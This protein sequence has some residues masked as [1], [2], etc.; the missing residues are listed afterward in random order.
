MEHTEPVAEERGLLTLEQ[1]DAG[2][3]LVNY[4]TRRPCK[5]S[6]CA[7]ITGFITMALVLGFVAQHA[8]PQSISLRVTKLVC[9][10]GW[11]QGCEDIEP[12][13][14]DMP[15]AQDY[16][17]ADALQE[18]GKER[19][20]IGEDF[21]EK[22]LSRLW[23]EMAWKD[24]AQQQLW[25]LT[26]L[27]EAGLS[28]TVNKQHWLFERAME[29]N[30][31]VASLMCDFG[32]AVNKT[33]SCEQ[34][35]NK[36][37]GDHYN[38]QQAYMWNRMGTIG[39]TYHTW[40]N[41]YDPKACF[42]E[43]LSR[44]WNMAA[45]WNGLGETL[46]GWKMGH[47][48]AAEIREVQAYVHALKISSNFS[49][50]WTNLGDNGGGTVNSVD[51]SAEHCYLKALMAKPE[52][53]LAWRGL[54]EAGGFT[55]KQK[56]YAAKNCIEH[57]LKL[58]PSDARIWMSL[59]KMGGGMFDGKFYSNKEC[60]QKALNLDNA[61]SAVRSKAWMLLGDLD[62]G[63]VNLT[64]MDARGCY[65]KA[66]EASQEEAESWAKL[67]NVGGG[68]VSGKKFSK[69]DCYQKAITQITSTFN[70]RYAAPDKESEFEANAS[71]WSGLG[72]LGG[73]HVGGKWVNAT[74]CYAAALWNK[75]DFSHAW[76]RLGDLGGA[77]VYFRLLSSRLPRGMTSGEFYD[78]QRCRDIAAHVNDKDP[79]LFVALGWQGGGN[80][81]G[82]HYDKTGSFIKALELKSTFAP[83]WN[84]LGQAGGGMVDSKIYSD[85]DCIKMAMQYQPD[86][87]DAWLQFC[88]RGGG[89]VNGINYQNAECYG[90]VLELPDSSAS[91]RRSAWLEL[92]KAGGGN[93]SGKWMDK[94]A[95]NRTADE[96]K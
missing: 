95:C 6:S 67:G 26:F 65:Q 7:A 61:A 88:F 10:G 89:D 25:S 44:N 35:K 24:E 94:K 27:K 57:A 79:E 30:S 14:Q 22:V 2:G 54:G 70:K 81:T 69:E 63:V 20:E 39:G 9:W 47:V 34:A 12:W 4:Q 93:V 42:Q 45:A 19:A 96:I 18:F 36:L 38:P 43:A 50:A 52:Y 49:E 73:A 62:G 86:Y 91:C 5:L 11:Y 56:N 85:M 53:A 80:V 40:G 64:A 1:A 8:V 87:A 58:D 3:L 41:W 13:P 28:E 71:A 74:A 23:H 32:M 31:Y 82:K 77:Y 55:H 17:L 72:D 46:K 76:V 60:L 21:K 59:S 92:A 51:Y 33:S 66:L 75:G 83:A 68:K 48:K 78:P 16:S 15:K 37:K 29:K 90:K 84:G